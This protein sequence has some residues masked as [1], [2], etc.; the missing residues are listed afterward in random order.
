MS[1]SKCHAIVV[2][3]KMSRNKSLGLKVHECK[4]R[5]KCQRANVT[6]KIQVS[7]YQKHK[8]NC[9]EMLLANCQNKSNFCSTSLGYKLHEPFAYNALLLAVVLYFGVSQHCRSVKNIAIKIKKLLTEIYIAIFCSTNL[10]RVTQLIN[11]LSPQNRKL[12]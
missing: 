3:A 11:L 10:I 5:N 4:S 1:G 8:H 6:S 2:S 12:R 9:H 7:S